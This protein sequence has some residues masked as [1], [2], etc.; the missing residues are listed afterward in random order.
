MSIRK[1]TREFTIGGDPEFLVIPKNGLGEP[2]RANHN[3]YDTDDG[4]IGADGCGTTFENRPRYSKEPLDVV[5]NIRANFANHFA[6]F[7]DFRRGDWKA[8]SY[9]PIV[10]LP[11][12][13]IEDDGWPLGGHIHFGLNKMWIKP[14]DLCYIMSQYVG[15]TT[16]LLEDKKEGKTRRIYHPETEDYDTYQYGLPDDFRDTVYGY[17][18]R[19]CSSWLTSPYVTA[20]VLC[21]AKVVMFEILNNPKMKVGRFICKKNFT[22]ME[23][24]LIRSRFPKIRKKIEAMHLFPQYSAYINFLF[25]LVDN[26]LTWYPKTS[27]KAAWGFPDAQV[28]RPIVKFSEIWS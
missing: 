7:E 28:T 6:L 4:S 14:E 2:L 19:T 12:G 24:E 27:M 17:E 15:S 9:F 22:H 16:M 18:Y 21:L 13:E 3:C 10:E 11:S 5:N 20:G 26:K 8:G 1:N 25:H 23:Q